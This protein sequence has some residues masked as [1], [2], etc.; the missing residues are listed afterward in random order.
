MS[1]THFRAA[2]L[3]LRPVSFGQHKAGRLQR[4]IPGN[5]GSQEKVNGRQAYYIIINAY[6]FIYILFY[7]IIYIFHIY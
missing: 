5:A 4:K 6:I 3:R 1:L 2:A 7:C